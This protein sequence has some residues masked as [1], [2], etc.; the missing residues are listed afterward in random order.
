MKATRALVRPPAPPEEEP[1]EEPPD[2]PPEEPPDEPP[3]ESPDEPEEEPVEEPECVA[4]DVPASAWLVPCVVGV[5]VVSVGDWVVGGVSA[6]PA[7]RQRARSSVVV[8]VQTI[9]RP[10]LVTPVAPSGE[11]KAPGLTCC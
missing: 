6:G 2:E 7:W 8:F 11:Q 4:A 3:E 5:L 9:G 1:P 10:V